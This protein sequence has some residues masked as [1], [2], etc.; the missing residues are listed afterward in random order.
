MAIRFNS[1]L[2]A[3]LVTSVIN[4]AARAS[5]PQW[6]D[7]LIYLMTA[8]G[9]IAGYMNWGGDFIKNIGVSSLPLAAD[10]IYSRIRTGSPAPVSGRLSY[11]GVGRYPAPAL[12]RPFAGVKLT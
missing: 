7:T 10:K 2:G 11:K 6:H 9:Y 3:P 5:F 4:I 12:E 1:D 8:G